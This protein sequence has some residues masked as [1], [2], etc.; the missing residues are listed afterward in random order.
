MQKTIFTSDDEVVASLVKGATVLE[1]SRYSIK[2]SNNT[3]VELSVDSEHTL[4]YTVFYEETPVF[5]L[6]E[7]YELYGRKYICT[8]GLNPDQT[9]IAPNAVYTVI[10]R[11]VSCHSDAPL[12]ISGLNTE[13]NVQA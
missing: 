10:L 2:F 9:G 3:I 13:I 5:M 4:D 1:W 7:Y 12:V 11:Q 6:Q 8:T